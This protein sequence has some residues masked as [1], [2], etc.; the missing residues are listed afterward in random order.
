MGLKPHV[1]RL[2]HHPTSVVRSLLGGLAK[3]ILEGGFWLAIG[4][5]VVV[6]GDVLPLNPGYEGIVT[7]PAVEIALG[8]AGFTLTLAWCRASTNP[9]E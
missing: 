6:A 2:Y 1:G 4:T 3:L 8:V 7:Y 5:L 9:Y